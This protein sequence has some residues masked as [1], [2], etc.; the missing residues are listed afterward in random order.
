MLRL[1]LLPLLAALALLAGCAHSSLHDDELPLE[2]HLAK[3]G[4]RQGE[5]VKSIPVWDTQGWEYLDK[6]HIVLGQAPGRRYLVAFSSPCNNLSFS[7][8]LN[9]SN[10]VGA[11]TP[12]DRIVSVDSAGIP[13]PCLIGQ[14]YR[15]E[16]MPSRAD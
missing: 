5:A 15:L 10:T 13:E 4:L 3:L 11:V 12:L 7:N 16:R 6:G 14:L 9:I 8:R 2:A 1:P